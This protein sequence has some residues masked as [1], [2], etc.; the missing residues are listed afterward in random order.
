MASQ[1]H[2]LFKTGQ[3]IIGMWETE[4][5]CACACVF[6]TWFA[7]RLVDFKFSVVSSRTLKTKQIKWDE[8]KQ[9]LREVFR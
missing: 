8:W 6:C 1:R 2:A 4:C 5:V 9:I 3:M 7:L